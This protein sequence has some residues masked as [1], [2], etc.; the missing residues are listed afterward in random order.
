M[1]RVTAFTH[2]RR[3]LGGEHLRPCHHVAPLLTTVP[4]DGRVQHPRNLIGVRHGLE[5]APAHWSAVIG[6]ASI[7]TP[8]AAAS[9]TEFYPQCVT[10]H[11]TARCRSAATCG[12]H[13]RITRPLPPDA[14]ATRSSNPS[15]SGAVVPAAHTN[16][17]PVRSSASASAASCG[18]CST[19][20][21]AK[22]MYTTEPSS[23]NL[24]SQAHR[25]TADTVVSPPRPPAASGPAGPTGPTACTRL[26][27]R[28]ASGAARYRSSSRRNVLDT[29]ADA[30]RFQRKLR[31]TCSESSSPSLYV[32]Y[33]S[34][35][36]LHGYTGEPRRSGKLMRLSSSVSSSR[37]G[38]RR[39]SEW[40]RSTAEPYTPDGQ[41]TIP[42]TPSSAAS[43]W[44]HPQEWSAS[45]ARTRS[46]VP[47]LSRAEE[48]SGARRPARAT[49]SAAKSVGGASLAHSTTEGR[50]GWEGNERTS[51]RM[52]PPSSRCAARSG[53]VAGVTTTV[54]RRPPREARRPVRSRS[55]IMWPCAGY[56][57]TRTWGAAGAVG[58][59]VAP[60]VAAM[61]MGRVA[62]RTGQ[63]CWRY[64]GGDDWWDGGGAVAA[65]ASCVQ[66]SAKATRM[67]AW[68]FRRVEG[69]Q[70]PSMSTL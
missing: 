9:N 12:A 4:T 65:A 52:A 51:A 58:W 1:P 37:L 35:N 41:N 40:R 42:G 67:A 18:G 21:L 13:P 25:S 31:R 57:T 69:E 26:R 8:A 14:A 68:W 62:Q 61:A 59:L 16:A 53:A 64:D 55:G 32:L 43:G 38:A 66:T 22:L 2:R 70:A 48:A 54:R 45:T 23:V 56:G 7:A 46:G 49:T 19:A 44:A 3:G 10:N 28:S 17:T 36:C 50:V 34:D 30:S 39:N 6:H 5:P 24:S 63:S 11:P 33:S 29:N 15:G 27:P 47:D 20:V 60:A